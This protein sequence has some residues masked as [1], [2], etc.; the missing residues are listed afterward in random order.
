MP[1]KNNGANQE[2]E[3]SFM[4]LN[5][6][7]LG[8]SGWGA[9][10]GWARAAAG[11]AAAFLSPPPEA[12][13]SALLAASVALPAYS[14]ASPPSSFPFAGGQRSG[15]GGE[16]TGEPACAGRCPA[17][18]R[19]LV[20]GV[21]LASSEAVFNFLLALGHD[22]ESIKRRNTSKNLSSMSMSKPMIT[23]SYLSLVN[24]V[25]NAVPLL[26]F[27]TNVWHIAEFL[28]VLGCLILAV[29]TTF[30]EHENVSAH[31]LVV[32]ET[33]AIFIFGAEFGLRIWA[34]GCCCRYKG[35]RGRLKFARKPLCILDIF[36]L[37]ASVPVVAVR[38]QG[39]VL[40]TSLRSLRFLQILR[41][42]RMDRR[43]G[44]WK[45][46]GS[47]IYAHS[48]ELITAWYI[49]FLSLILASFLVYLVEKDDVS[50]DVS[51]N[52]DP[53]AQARTQDFDTYADALWWGLITLTTIGYGDKTPKT[54]AGRLLAGT[55]ALIGVSFFAL[56]A[57][58]LGSGLALKVQEQHRQ[59]H[60]EKR[61]HP[62]AGLIQSAWRYYSTNPIREDLIA[63]W[64]FYE[65][66]ISLPCFRKD[67][68][69]TMASQKLSLLE[70]VR[71][72]N[73]KPL[74]GMNR[75]PTGNADSIEESP[76][77]EPKPAG[78][79]N[80]ERFRTAFRMKAYTLR[81][82]SEDA[83]AL[84]D[85]ALEERGFPAD[86]LME[87]MIPTLKLVIR[88]VRIM[89]FLLNKKRFKETLRPYDVKDVIEQYSAGHLDMLCRIKY[90]QTRIDMILAP[91]PL[92]TPK[93]KKT[94]KTPFAYPSNQSPKHETYLAKTASMA[95]N[96]DQ[97]MMGRFVRVE[98][99]V[100]DMEKKLD[101]LV[102]MHIQH[103]EHL[104]V[105]S[106]GTAHMTLETCDTAGNG[107]IRRVFLNYAE[108]FPHMSY[109][110]P[111]SKGNSFLRGRAA[112]DGRG[113]VEGG[114]VASDQQAPP[115]SH[116]AIPTY[117]ERPTVLPISSLQDISVR[118]GRTTGGRGADSPLSMLSVN[119]EELERSL[120]G[121]SI[122]G[123]REGENGDELSIGTGL[124]TGDASW[125]RP[126][127]NYLAEGET[128]T[129]TDPFTPSG[130]PL[131]LSSTGEGF[132][133]AVW[134]TPP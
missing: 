93:H 113:L 90:L 19:R 128:D 52:E 73:A 95:D 5:T 74:V 87:D 54:W 60:F 23:A 11:G 18:G 77:K 27:P 30:K 26:S 86:I 34:A 39:N 117:T 81:Q 63:T 131:P 70:R 121:F 32:L 134:N 53:T 118:P 15:Q 129:D 40:A 45:L 20:G 50:V 17:P 16:G 76:S 122:S 8:R 116:G 28:I 65:T 80:R 112:K 84:A 37:I 69:E 49:G 43:G 99:Q 124:A 4:H 57:G 58:I 25:I 119:H 85:P 120:S 125:T 61:R 105:D 96:E 33:F 107:E 7:R 89:Q 79:S 56:P 38:N 115:R 111:I 41:M 75:K 114:L 72:P 10:R 97:S 2:D 103:T 126:R 102:D 24:K 51:D 82:S 67:T 106:A 68:M 130:G 29:L 9:K 59:K 35:W 98:R 6:V 100:E 127:P 47:A 123:E 71:L 78:F 109:Q 64:R 88:A 104:Q 22:H 46:L 62:A 110:V 3:D 42:L 36:V 92:L 91:G 12:W 1:L 13:R 101:F 133:E 66:I 83:G 14:L 108:A 31:W 55:F 132:G 48:K 21:F 94:Q 44:T